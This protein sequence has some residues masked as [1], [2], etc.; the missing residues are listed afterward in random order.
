MEVT[1][2]K[3]VSVADLEAVYG[4]PVPKSHPDE[5]LQS[6][7]QS[8]YMFKAVTDGKTVGFAIYAIWWGNCP[9]LELVKVHEDFRRGGIGSKL[10]ESVFVEVKIK[11][12]SKMISSTEVK[13]DSGMNWH[14][15][16]NFTKLNILM[17]PHGEEQFF[18][19]EL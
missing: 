2:S 3:D 10:L 11:G 6:R 7:M 1:I 4:G 17:L 15:K 14:L 19:K 5:Y 16:N 8:G 12:F 18:T 13:N 9:F